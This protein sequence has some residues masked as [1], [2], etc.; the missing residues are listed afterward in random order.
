M[1]YA[2][3]DGGSIA[4]D[5]IWRDGRRRR[6]GIG[7]AHGI[8]L[9]RVVAAGGAPSTCKNGGDTIGFTWIPLR[10][11]AAWT[12]L[13]EGRFLV[14]YPSRGRTGVRVAT[15]QRVGCCGLRTKLIYVDGRGRELGRTTYRAYAAG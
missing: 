6:C 15:S 5:A 4:C 11:D 9:A 10:R 2:T 13:D 1:G 3:T 12:L 7:T 14:A 8:G